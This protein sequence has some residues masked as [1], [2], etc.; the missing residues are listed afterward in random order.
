M[1]QGYCVFSTAIDS[2]LALW[3]FFSSN[4]LHFVFLKETTAFDSPISLAGAVV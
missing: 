4:C 2:S 1:T 3:P